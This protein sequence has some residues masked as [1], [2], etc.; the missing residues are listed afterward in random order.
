MITLNK[1]QGNN[2]YHLIRVRLHPDETLIQTDLLP[3]KKNHSDQGTQRTGERGF[4][5]NKHILPTQHFNQD[6]IMALNCC[7]LELV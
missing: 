7:W 1:V 2:Y 3:D 4:G 6:P 5:K